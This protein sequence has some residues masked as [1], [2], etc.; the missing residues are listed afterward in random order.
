MEGRYQIGGRPDSG[1]LW[2]STTFDDILRLSAFSAEGS[3]DNRG[4]DW[5]I[6]TVLGG[7]LEIPALASLFKVSEAVN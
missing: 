7:Q 2:A 3:R 4:R 5:H 6:R 1:L